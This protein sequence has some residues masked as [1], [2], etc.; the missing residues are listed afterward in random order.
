MGDLRRLGHLGA[1][2]GRPVIHFD[3]G[4]CANC[5]CG[6]QASVLTGSTDV[7]VDASL[8]GLF[9]QQVAESC[10]TNAEIASLGSQ[11]ELNGA[12]AELLI[13]SGGFHEAVAVIFGGPLLALFGVLF[14]ANSGPVWWTTGWTLGA[15]ASGVLLWVHL[16]ARYR[17]RLRRRLAVRLQAP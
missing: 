4:R 8:D 15:V 1:R 11:R 7:N 9:G 6:A 16:V 14:I 3:A 10:T 2:D 17:P 12:G 5:T 13:S